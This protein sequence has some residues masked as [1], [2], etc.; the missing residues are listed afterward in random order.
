MAL[1]LLFS[2]FLI[3]RDDIPGWWIWFYYMNPISYAIMG[4]FINEFWNEGFS[5]TTGELVP[6]VSYPRFSL[7][8]P[9]GFAGESFYMF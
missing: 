3:A 2:G 7:P 4:L 9:T 1:L 6:P 5:C 8:Y